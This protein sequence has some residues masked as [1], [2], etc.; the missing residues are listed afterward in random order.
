[1]IYDQDF[2]QTWH[3][4]QPRIGHSKTAIKRWGPVVV[5]A[6]SDRNSECFFLVAHEAFET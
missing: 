1:M 6:L 5:F 3:K 4:R 2:F